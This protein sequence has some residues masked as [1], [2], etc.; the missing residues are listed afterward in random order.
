MITKIWSA[1]FIVFAVYT[2]MVYEYSGSGQHLSPP[3][4]NV[5]QGWDIWQQKNCHTCHQLYG[6]GGY[7]GP[8]LTNMIS[9]P[10]KGPEYMRIFIKY[11]TTRMPDFH[12]SDKEVNDVLAFLKWVDKSGKSRVDSKSVHWTG[13]YLLK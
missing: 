3:P 9:D 1:L 12:L 13:T 5:R 11:G 10:G 4:A 7:M 8:D 6:L 2:A